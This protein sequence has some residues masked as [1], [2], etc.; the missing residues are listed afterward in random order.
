LEQE[1]WFGQFFNQLQKASSQL[2]LGIL[3]KHSYVLC[4]YCH[5]NQTL[6]YLYFKR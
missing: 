3:L 5:T 4:V 6:I 1:V 2:R